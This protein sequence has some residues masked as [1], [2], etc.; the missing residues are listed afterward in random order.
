VLKNAA[1]P[2]VNSS[3][4]FCISIPHNTLTFCKLSIAKIMAKQ[5]LVW[6]WTQWE[7]VDSDLLSN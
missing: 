1:E 4:L 7:E 5:E 3:E 6:W 2:K